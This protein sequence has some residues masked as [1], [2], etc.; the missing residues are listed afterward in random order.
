VRPTTLLAG[1]GGIAFGVLTFL[2]LIVAGPAG[3]SY[4]ASDVASYVASGHRTAVFVALYLALVGVAGLILLLARLRETVVGGASGFS[5]TPGIV[6]GT[7]LAAAA[8]FAIG[9]CVVLSVPVDYAYAGGHTFVITSPV[10]YTI[11]E[12]GVVIV[13]GGGGILLGLT[14]LALGI[15]SGRVFPVWMRWLTIIVGVL[16]LASLAFFPWFALLIWAVIA[17]IWLLMSEQTSQAV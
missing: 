16:G 13:Y 7:G 8:C 10:A 12:T 1:I 17:G 15:G 3:G 14:L 4:T 9:W 6:W 11:L 2:A 5:M